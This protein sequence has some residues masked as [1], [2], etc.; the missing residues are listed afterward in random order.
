M[1]KE[2]ECSTGDVIGGSLILVL[3][4]MVGLSVG[5]YI[6]EQ[7]QWSK[8]Q[9]EVSYNTLSTIESTYYTTPELKPFIMK[10]LK[11]NKLTEAEYL[12]IQKKDREINVGK[13]IKALRESLE[14]E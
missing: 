6:G 8:F 10:C 4:V 5:I 14:K 9:T 13:R 1:S 3:A 12:L 2:S 7:W 11:D